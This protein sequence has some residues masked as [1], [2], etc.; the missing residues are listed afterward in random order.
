MIGSG[1]PESVSCRGNVGVAEVSD[2]AD[3]TAW[4][5]GNS[6]VTTDANGVNAWADQSG[7]GYDVTQATDAKKPDNTDTQNGLTVIT[8]D[9]TD[10]ELAYG[11]SLFTAISQPN[12]IFLVYQ[13]TY[14]DGNAR[15]PLDGDGSGTRNVIYRLG[16]AGY[17]LAFHAGSTADTGTGADTNMHVHACVFDGASSDYR[18]DGSYIMQAGNVGTNALDGITLGSMYTSNAPAHV[19]IAEALFYDGEKTLSEMQAIE[20]ELNAKWAV[21]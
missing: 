6:G 13:W 9:G 14:L 19:R 17:N 3:L 5:R 18:L 10:D 20:V 4:Y 2:L 15:I 8:F 16:S 11:V 21:Y 12:T 7:N 1:I